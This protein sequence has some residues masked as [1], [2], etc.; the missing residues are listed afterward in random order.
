MNAPTPLPRS[1]PVVVDLALYGL[2]Q[3]SRA[4][5]RA[6]VVV[7]ARR[8]FEGFGDGVE[9]VAVSVTRSSQ[10][11]EGE[12]WAVIV[13]V[14]L[15]GSAGRIVRSHAYARRPHTALEGALLDAWGDVHALLRAHPTPEPAR[16]IA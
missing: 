14:V 5:L 2:D 8:A 13:E 15:A 6:S 10:H 4:A 16:A 7:N 1:L 9:S 12:L 11:G 3:A